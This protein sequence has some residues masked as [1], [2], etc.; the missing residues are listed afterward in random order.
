MGRLAYPRRLG[1]AF[2]HL[3]ETLDPSRLP[4][5]AG[6]ATTLIITTTL[7]ALRTELATAEL[8]TTAHVP[9]HN[10]TADTLTAAEARRLA[11]TATLIPAV[12]GGDSEPLDLGRARRLFTP[13]QRKALLL[14][15]KTCR[16][17][18]CTIPGT[19]CEAHHPQPWQHGGP[20]DLDNGLLLCRHHHQQAHNASYQ[21]HRQPDGQLRY[22][23]RC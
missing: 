7:D 14:R 12:L 17:E 1:E 13:A 21:T 19:W 10:P 5:H 9:G 16:A 3:I 15:D 20:T 8:L 6:D 11:C 22:T 2:C 18:G 23:S 4:L